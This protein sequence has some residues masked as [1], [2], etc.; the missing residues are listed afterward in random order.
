MASRHWDSW[1]VDFH[2]KTAG[3]GQEGSSASHKAC[4]KP[5]SGEWGVRESK[6]VFP[7]SN[8]NIQKFQDRLQEEFGFDGFVNLIL[9]YWHFAPTVNLNH[10]QDEKWHV[11]AI[12]SFKS[13]TLPTSSIGNHGI[14]WIPPWLQVILLLIPLKGSHGIPSTSAF[15]QW[16]HLATWGKC[17]AELLREEELGQGPKLEDSC[18]ATA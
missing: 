13:N 7:Q 2:Q 16:I 15:L 5:L 1:L 10:R 8:H 11:Q 9:F 17:L 4:E 14:Q 6:E 3:T 18:P 12:H